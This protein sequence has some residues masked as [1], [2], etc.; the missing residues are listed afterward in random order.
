MSQTEDDTV[1]ATSTIITGDKETEIETNE[2][3]DAT[4]A[5]YDDDDTSTDSEDSQVEANKQKRIDAENKRI[6]DEIQARKDYLQNLENGANEI[7]E[8]LTEELG[9]NLDNPTRFIQEETLKLTGLT[10]EQAFAIDT[11]AIHKKVSEYHCVLIAEKFYAHV[12][13]DPDEWFR[14]YFTSDVDDASM[15]LADFMTQRFGGEPNYSLRKGFTQLAKRHTDFEMSSRTAERWLEHMK[16][17]L[18]DMGDEISPKFVTEMMDFFRYTAY[19]MVTV[20][21]VSKHLESVSISIILF[22]FTMLCNYLIHFLCCSIIT[23]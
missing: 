14:A 13:E 8:D 12:M 20:Q 7:A 17:A 2:D 15:N 16:S 18:E 10:Y 11:S 4:L 6:A 21:R 3:I 22:D 1:T 9:Y 5:A 23:N 19:Y